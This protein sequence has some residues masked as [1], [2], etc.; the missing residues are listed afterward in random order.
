MSARSLLKVMGLAAAVA[1]VPVNLA[2]A[3]T[4][5]RR[6]LTQAKVL[7]GAQLGVSV[8]DVET[9]DVT[10][11]KL[12]SLSGA[13]LENVRP[14]SPAEKA[15]FKTGDVVT[16]FDGERVR[17]ASQ[18]LRL[19]DETPDAREVDVVVQRA[20]QPVT[21]K[22]AP[23]SA[24]SPF[25][26]A[27]TQ[28]NPPMTVRFPDRAF[29]T[30]KL[31]AIANLRNTFTYGYFAGSTPLG[32]SV[33]EVSGQL[34]EFFGTATGL[35]V[36]NVEDGTVGK[37]AGLKA[38]DVITKVNGTAVTGVADLRRTLTGDVTITIVR[39]KKEQ[40]IKATIK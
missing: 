29:T 18:F 1:V 13:Y 28:A 32:V 12:S 30:T 25:Y 35:L 3:Q 39:D 16:T 40:T 11:E 20:G 26:R 15:G 38:G 10:R 6:P 24:W 2:S 22:V 23:E 14:G 21:L 33:Q 9:A 34:G 4:V 19:I 8:R 36:T 5:Q 27:L 37:T 17:S 7:S 31:P